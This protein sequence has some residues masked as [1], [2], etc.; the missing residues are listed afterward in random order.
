MRQTP[1]TILLLML[2]QPFFVFCQQSNH[3]SP[4]SFYFSPSLGATFANY[5][6]L[7]T[8]LSNNGIRTFGNYH[9]GLGLNLGMNYKNFTLF[10]SVFNSYGLEVSGDSFTN[11][12]DINTTEIGL[13]YKMNLTK[14]NN[15]Q[16]AV[17]GSAGNLFSNVELSKTVNTA[18]FNSTI[19]QSGNLLVINN[20][21]SY[22]SGG[23]GFY[24]KG[25]DF[26][27]YNLKIGYRVNENGSP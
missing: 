13:E 21:S 5:K 2:L 15:L 11:S 18:N 25:S 19:S 17:F 20:F 26:V 8:T 7:N 10:A 16:L 12:T 3:K 14:E 4:L 24:Y 22:L 23:L 6:N 1:K 9:S 27:K